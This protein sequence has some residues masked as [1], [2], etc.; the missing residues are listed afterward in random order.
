[1]SLFVEHLVYGRNCSPEE[2]EE[3]GSEWSLE[4]DIDSAVCSDRTAAAAAADAMPVE[5]WVVSAMAAQDF[6]KQV[7]QLLEATVEGG[8]ER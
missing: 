8:V 5:H 4:G 6:G 1:M 7:H 3:E 2:P